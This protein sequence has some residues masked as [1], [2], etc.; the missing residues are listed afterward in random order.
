MGMT[1]LILAMIGLYGLVTYSVS[2]R[3]R[4]FG[5]RMAVGASRT[6]LLA[7]V[8]GQGAKL[9]LAGVTIGLAL[10]LP[11]SHLLS[12][13]VFTANTDWVPY[14][15]IPVILI[16]VTLFSTFGPARRAA[17]IDPMKALRDE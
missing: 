15:Q 4:E 17:T 16:A 7:M 12:A 2:R 1:G 3:T 13:F 10:S 9:C 5:I 11:A 14:L 8:L 6:G